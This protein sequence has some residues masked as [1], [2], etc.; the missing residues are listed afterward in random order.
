MKFWMWLRSNPYFVTATSALFGALLNGLYQEVQPG[1]QINWSA[2]GWES[3]GATVVVID[4][5]SCRRRM[6]RQDV[7]G[8]LPGVAHGF[9]FMVIKHQV[10]RCHVG[11]IGG[12]VTT[13]YVNL[14][15]LHIFGVDK[16]NVVNQ[17]QLFKQYS[18]HQ[19]VKVT[20]GYQSKFFGCHRM[21]S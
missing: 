18:A 12:D 15:I 2:S 14:A 9:R 4:H 13:A 20:A 1:H 3:L 10:C 8:P 17:V 7:V 16:L 5:P 21:G 6:S 19:A 11:Q